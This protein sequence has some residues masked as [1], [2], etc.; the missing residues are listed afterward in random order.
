MSQSFGAYQQLSNHNQSPLKPDMRD[1]ACGSSGSDLDI[2]DDSTEE[3]P[4]N[5]KF[6]S[7]PRGKHVLTAHIAQSSPYTKSA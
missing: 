3:S 7:R 6:V 1:A 5:S 4:L 2:Y